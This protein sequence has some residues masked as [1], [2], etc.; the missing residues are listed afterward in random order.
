MA[1]ARFE[2]AAKV[3]CYQCMINSKGDFNKCNAVLEICIAKKIVADKLA[4]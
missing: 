1:A 3:I 2:A 4:L